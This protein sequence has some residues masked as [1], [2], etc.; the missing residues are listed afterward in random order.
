MIKLSVI[1]ETAAVNAVG[2][3]SLSSLCSWLMILFLLP[4][5][6]AGLAHFLEMTFE[7]GMIFR[8][9]F[10]LLTY[11]LWFKPRERRIT[12]TY[13]K[14]AKWYSW[15]YKPLGGCLWCFSVWLLI[16]FW[17]ITTKEYCNSTW[18][19]TLIS[20]PLVIGIQFIWLNLIAK[21]KV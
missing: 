20:L 15:F 16:A 14:P 18:I 1:A 13:M 4:I 8:K 9:Y 5:A 19:F 10:K 3:P 12:K 11:W 6:T 21:I 2:L 17:I 7:K